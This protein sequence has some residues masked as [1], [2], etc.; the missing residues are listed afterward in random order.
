MWT[1]EVA[2]SATEILKVP[3]TTPC[4]NTA[5]VPI[6][7]LGDLAAVEVQLPDPLGD[8]QALWR[9][10]LQ[11]Q[12]RGDHPLQVV[13]GKIKALGADACRQRFAGGSIQ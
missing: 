7:I 11:L 12:L 1:E 5:Y 13:L 6:R 2:A 4:E 9:A 3:W 8:L 10:L